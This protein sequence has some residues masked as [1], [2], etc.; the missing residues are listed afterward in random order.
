MSKLEKMNKLFSSTL[1]VLLSGFVPAAAQSINTGEID[2][3]IAGQMQR[4]N[5]PG[6]GLALVKDG[7][8][9]Y[10]KG[11]GVRDS[12]TNTPVNADTLFAI[13]SVSKS[14]T[15]LGIMQLVSLGKIKLDAPVTTY[16][17]NLKFSDA[18]KGAKVTV[19]QLLS[20]TSGL[21]RYDDWAIDKTI[22][23]RQK[24]LETIAQIPFSSTPGM[25]FAYNNQNYVAAGAVLEA[26]TKQSWEAYTKNNILEPMG[27]KRTTLGF[28]EAQQDNNFA[29]GHN[30]GLQGVQP[31]P[32]FDRFPV[33]A[34]AGS[35]HSSATEM[36]KYLIAQMGKGENRVPRS[37]TKEMHKTQIAI[38]NPFSSSIGGMT[39]T[40]Y[41]LGWIN[42]EYRG[43]KIV[44]HGGNING[45]S[46]EVQFLPQKGWGMV[47]LTNTNNA[48]AFLNST[49]LSL[50]E[51]LL[52]LRPRSD[53]SEAPALATQA[54]LANAKNFVAKFD[55]LKQLEGNYALIT[56]DTIKIRLENNQLIVTQQGQ[57]FRLIP[58]S[59]TKYIVDFDGFFLLLEFQISANGMTWLIQDDQ[60]VG[61]K[62]PGTNQAA[63]PVTTMLTDSKNQYSTVLPAGLQVVQTTSQFTVVQSDS[64]EAAFL[65]NV[66]EAKASL[67]ETALAF[68]K[69]LEPN[70][71]LKPSQNSNLPAINGIVW[72]QMLYALPNNQTLAVFATQKGNNMYLVAVQAE[73]KNLNALTPYIQQILSSYKIL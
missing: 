50:T 8:V 23:T 73:T 61:V 37:Q 16:L 28:I 45:F 29:Q 7:K 58:A 72:T 42:E 44:T 10:T 39:A 41:G 22:N 1:L 64:P 66:S 13:G 19:R 12:K 2:T 36:A 56:G 63:T 25:K 62:I 40:G 51:E 4:Y 54:V 60:V 52:N 46:A 57:N 31:I 49:R 27:M 48:N 17:P 9:V 67:E 11:Y 30:A 68:I 38:G 70:F 32:A 26:I 34:P 69:Q 15:S 33:V 35:I 24:V 65:F 3:F 18:A 47:L 5:V 21:E 59:N 53:F 6:L 43:V 55:T 14:F 20:M 71:N